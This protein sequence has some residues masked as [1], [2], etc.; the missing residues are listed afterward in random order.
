MSSLGRFLQFVGLTVLPL[1][2]LMQV[3]DML[4]RPLHVS[5]MVFMLIFGLAAFYM[6]RLV[7]GYA[8]K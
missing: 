5:Q 2:M 4:G 8:R 1:S 6:G 3:T 7:E